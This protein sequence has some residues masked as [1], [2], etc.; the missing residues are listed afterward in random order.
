MKQLLLPIPPSLHRWP[1]LAPLAILDAALAASELA[2]LSACPEVHIE[3]FNRS[4]RGSTTRRAYAVITQA[5]R[6][7]AATAAYRHAVERDARRADRDLRRR[8]F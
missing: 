4:P 5:R 7:A 3:A 6:L 2:L 1:E 8:T